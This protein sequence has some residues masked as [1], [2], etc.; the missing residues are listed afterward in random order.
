MS[1]DLDILKNVSNQIARSQANSSKKR[2]N[3]DDLADL[4]LSKGI[5]TVTYVSE[6]VPASMSKASNVK[7]DN[8]FV[9]DAVNSVSHIQIR[10]TNGQLV[11]GIRVVIPNNELA[12]LKVF[13]D[14][15]RASEDPDV[16]S[17]VES[18]KSTK[19]NVTPV[20]CSLINVESGFTDFA[21]VMLIAGTRR[22]KACR[23]A[24][25]DLLADIILEHVSDETCSDIAFIENT[26][27]DNPDCWAMSKFYAS[28]FSLSSKNVEEFARHFQV[29]RQT[30]S[31]YLNLAK[32]PNWI[33][34]ISPRYKKES[35][36]I[37][38]AWSMRQ[39]ISLKSALSHCD[40]HDKFAALKDSIGHLR[41]NDPDELIKAIVA[42]SN[43]EPK[44]SSSLKKP[45]IYGHNSVGEI[46]HGKRKNTLAIKLNENAPNE[47]LVE[48]KALLKKFGL[49]D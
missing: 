45:L 25:A 35:D 7:A 49:E 13:S 17:L 29:A 38:H 46:S 9:I 48:I 18:V 14:N 28:R 40:E 30:M 23:I 20:I 22:H 32:I 31:E 19:G 26:E 4:D 15:P 2:A 42:L 47:L 5:E 34:G 16:T 43:V 12:Q 39:A 37:V 33:V 10:L 3:L 27:R 6:S 11:K 36:R 41:Y 1:R 21:N 44:N 8:S 24:G